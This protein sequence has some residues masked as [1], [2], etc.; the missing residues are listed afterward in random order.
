MFEV[1][2]MVEKRNGKR[3]PAEKQQLNLWL[4]TRVVEAL[5][6]AAERDLRS[7]GSQATHYIKLGLDAD[8]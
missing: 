5:K 2:D 6:Q 8:R 1:S 4:E 3:K 7:I